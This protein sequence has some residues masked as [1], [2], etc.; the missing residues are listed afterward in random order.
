MAKKKAGRKSKYQLLEIDEKLPLIEGWIRD[1][2]TEK[3][4][5]ASLGVAEK[6]FNEWKLQYPQ[7][8]QSL[9]KGREFQDRLV[10]NKLLQKISG[11][12]AEET[13]VI[14]SDNG[15][16]VKRKTKHISPDTTAIIFWLK[17]RLPE[18]W[19]DKMVQD[20]N[21]SGGVNMFSQ[22]SDQELEEELKKLRGE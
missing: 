11:Y 3:S 9:K 2:Y 15:T 14:E 6:T 18:K 20:I 5:A 22:M 13:E 8:K 17:N 4:I 1:G 7:L 12:E 16:T 19:A 21:H 10:E